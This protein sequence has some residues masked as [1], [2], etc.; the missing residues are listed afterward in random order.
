MFNNQGNQGNQGTQGPTNQSQG[1][2]NN[3]FNQKPAQNPGQGGQTQSIFPNK[4]NA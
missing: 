2:T 3:M 4:Q 1:G